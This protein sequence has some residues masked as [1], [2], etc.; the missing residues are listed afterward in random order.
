[1]KGY[2]MPLLTYGEGGDKGWRGKFAGPGGHVCCQCT[3]SMWD[4]TAKR[5]CSDLCPEQLDGTSKVLK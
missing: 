2:E 4:H 1:M 5:G 3:Y